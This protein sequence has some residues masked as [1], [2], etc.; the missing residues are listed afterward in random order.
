MRVAYTQ[1]RSDSTRFHVRKYFLT[2][3]IRSNFIVWR[4]FNH[5]RTDFTVIVGIMEFRFDFPVL[6]VRRFSNQWI[7]KIWWCSAPKQMVY[8]TDWSTTNDG[9]FYNGYA[10]A[11][12]RLR[13]LQCC[14]HTR[15]IQKG[16]PIPH[17]FQSIRLKRK[18][19]NKRWHHTFLS[20]FHMRA[21]CCIVFGNGVMWRMRAALTRIR[22]KKRE[23]N[24]QK[25]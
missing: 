11:C 14:L 8:V 23:A 7:C 13:F 24:C 15:L 10:E 2:F 12:F 16:T 1:N 3:F 21:H 5:S 25:K 4:S 19:N 18:I 20:F 17:S 6:W 22:R 9:D